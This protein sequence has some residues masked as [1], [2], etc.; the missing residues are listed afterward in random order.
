MKVIVHKRPNFRKI[1]C[2][3]NKK[4]KCAETYLQLTKHYRVSIILKSYLR[5]YKTNGYL[6]INNLLV[7]F[8]N[9]NGQSKSSRGNLLQ[10]YI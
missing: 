10:S 7:N 9:F 3:R 8:K 2:S 5:K 4:D 6:I 1:I